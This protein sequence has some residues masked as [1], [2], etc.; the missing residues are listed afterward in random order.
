MEWMQTYNN[1]LKY[2]DQARFTIQSNQCRKHVL[3]LIIYKVSR[4]HPRCSKM[5]GILQEKGP[6][7]TDAYLQAHLLARGEAPAS[8]QAP[9][10]SPEGQQCSC[11]TCKIKRTQSPKEAQLFPQTNF[12]WGQRRRC[13]MSTWTLAVRTLLLSISPSM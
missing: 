9:L 6:W 11:N 10:R 7:H 5:R 4:P 3:E 8:F 1:H 12:F 13:S 2:A